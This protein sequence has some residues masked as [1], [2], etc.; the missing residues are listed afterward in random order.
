MTEACVTYVSFNFFI[1]NR[2]LRYDVFYLETPVC[3]T[4]AD[5]IF[6]DF[7]I[8]FFLITIDMKH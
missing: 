4:F 8:D 7:T 5:V 3:E 6:G 1:Q 2:A